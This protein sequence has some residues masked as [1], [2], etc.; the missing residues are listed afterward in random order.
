MLRIPP[1]VVV[2]TDQ[3]LVS[4]DGAM[5]LMTI[6]SN[7]KNVIPVIPIRKNFSLK[8]KGNNVRKEQGLLQLGNCKMNSQNIKIFDDLTEGKSKTMEERY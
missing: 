6:L 7:V 8:T 2:P 3:L 5:I 1:N 4:V